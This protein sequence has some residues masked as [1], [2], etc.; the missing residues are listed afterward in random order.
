MVSLQGIFY[1]GAVVVIITLIA[2]HIISYM[3]SVRSQ[4]EQVTV[5][6]RAN[7]MGNFID[8]ISLDMPRAVDIATKRALVA[9]IN[10]VDLRGS[11]LDDAQLRLRELVM[12]GTI[13]GSDSY[14]LNASTVPEWSER[15]QVIGG[16]KGFDVNFSFSSF[17]V[18]PYDSFHLRADL[19]WSVN[20]SDRLVS[21]SV[22]RSYNTT[23]LI[24]IANL[25]DPLYPMHTRGLANRKVV[26]ANFTSYNLTTLDTIVANSLYVNSSD[27]PS[28]MDRLED[29][30]IVPSKY[31]LMTSSQIG[32]ASIVNV[33]DLINYGLEVD[34]NQ[35]SVDYV[36]FGTIPV[37][38]YPVNGSSY[39]WLRLNDEQ[40]QFY[41]VNG[42]LDYG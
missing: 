8:S 35:T 26:P 42:S 10:E 20:L 16:N 40:A 34:E 14:W 19:E 12:N 18:S 38:G 39:A 24:P 9:G 23:V 7:E 30:L 4:G 6:I 25:D 5:L 11:G 13:Y 28:F 36:Y 1:S 37:Q 32:L 27:G 2:F 41:G 15:V 31:N 17:A 29:N 3:D 22:R 33:Q 21:M